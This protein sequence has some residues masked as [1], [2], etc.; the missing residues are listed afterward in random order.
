MPRK[1]TK[2]ERKAREESERLAAM[3]RMERELYKLKLRRKAMLAARRLFRAREEIWRAF[4]NGI[5]S[6]DTVH[7][8]PERLGAFSLEVQHGTPELRDRRRPDG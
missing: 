2:K 5:L 4:H 6:L 7:E 1:E 3:S 8:R